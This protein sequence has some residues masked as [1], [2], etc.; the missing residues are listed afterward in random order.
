MTCLPKNDLIYTHCVITISKQ[1]S[2]YFF[3]KFEIV[4]NSYFK[5]AAR[6]FTAEA[7]WVL[8]D[9]TEACLYIVWQRIKLQVSCIKQKQ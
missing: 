2:E 4:C 6:I 8:T 1:F 9:A 5:N 7:P 3:A